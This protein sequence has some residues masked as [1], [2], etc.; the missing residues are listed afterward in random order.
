MSK[1]KYLEGG[2]GGAPYCWTQ[3]VVGS[4][5]LGEVEY[6]W[7]FKRGSRYDGLEL[8]AIMIGVSGL[9]SFDPL[10]MTVAFQSELPR[11]VPN[12]GGSYRVKKWSQEDFKRCL[13]KISY[14]VKLKYK[15][16]EFASCGRE[17][18]DLMDGNW[19]LLYTLRAH[20]WIHRSAIYHHVGHPL[21]LMT[22][23]DMKH[24]L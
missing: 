11:W 9:S 18:L 13:Y 20:E 8:V 14:S 21:I 3:K 23:R 16:L 6:W 4:G 10:K 15:F 2:V 24:P 19:L 1:F 12:P 7:M 17:V 5:E 22:M